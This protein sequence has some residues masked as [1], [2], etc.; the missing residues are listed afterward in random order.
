MGA[1]SAL[2]WNG[3]KITERVTS[4]TTIYLFSNSRM[5]Q[6]LGWKTN[7]YNILI[8]LHC[9][10]LL[11]FQFEETGYFIHEEIRYVPWS[12]PLKEFSGEGVMKICRKFTRE[13]PCQSAT[14]INSA[15]S[16][17]FVGRPVH[18][19]NPRWRYMVGADRRKFSIYLLNLLS[20]LWFL[21]KTFS[22]LLKFTLRKILLWGWFL[23]N[24]CIQI[25]FKYS[26][27]YG[28]KLRR[29]A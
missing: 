16:R 5:L 20:I 4:Q 14:S 8:S 21:C 2:A 26:N 6:W 27:L 3:L 7:N 22:K 15:A 9:L 11:W 19:P 29:A 25:K 1:A 23:K 17:V 24:S 12:S 13:Q 18:T 28:Y 10:I